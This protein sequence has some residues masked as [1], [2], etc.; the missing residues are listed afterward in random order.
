MNG[1]SAGAK[2]ALV[3]RNEGFVLVTVLVM[4]A[5]L[6]ML[7]VGMFMAS[8]ATQQD[9][10]VAA[11]AA[12]AGYYAETAI[13]YM[14]WAW[15]ND[16]ELD[17]PVIPHASEDSKLGDR[18]EWQLAPTNPGPTTIGGTG[19]QVMYFDN[20]PLANR[21]VRWPLPVVGGVTQYPVLRGIN[22]RLST[23]LRVDIDAKGNIT[24]TP[25]KAA[26]AFP[27]HGAAPKVDV[28]KTGAIVWLTAG[29]AN[30]D[31]HL[32]P[33]AAACG[34]VSM[35]KRGQGCV[36]GPPG[37]LIMPRYYHVIAYAVGYVNGKPMRLV[38]AVIE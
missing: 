36:D 19:G 27:H 37:I 33:T 7:G 26:N 2:M 11:R 8:L 29:D 25:R 5:L 3:K 13:E 15:A 20:T 22:A 18:A 31:L 6:T 17:F 23:Y 1:R 24:V 10:A 16:A 9:S 35:L 34:G 28:P 14:R 21:A 38:R 32:D 30:Q 12:Q 4:L